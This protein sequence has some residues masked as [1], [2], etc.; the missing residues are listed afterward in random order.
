MSAATQNNKRIALNTLFLY[1]RMLVTMLVSLYTSRVVLDKLGVTDYGI[2]NIVGGIVTMLGF[3]NNSMSNAVQRYMSFEIGKNNK[4]GVNVIFNISLT[5]HFCIAIIVLII[6]EICGV[7]YLNNYMNIPSNRLE[8]ANWVLQCSILTT[9]FTIIQVPYNAIIISYERMSIFAYISILEVTLKLAIVFLLSIGQFDKL[10]LYSILIAIVTISILI[11]YQQYCKKKFI[12][13]RFRF[14]KDWKLL[15]QLI[16]FASWN[17]LG[18]LAWIFTGQ[19]V[20]LILNFFWGPTLNAARGLADQVNGA[21]T[22]FISNFQTAVNPQIIKS[23]ATEHIYEMKSLLYRST[24]FSFY[25]MLALALPL[26]INMDFILHIWLKDVPQYTTEFC[27]LTL[28]CSLIST[29]SNLLAQVARA[30]GDIRNYQIGISIMLFLNFPLSYIFLKEGYSPTC[31]ITINI[32]I[33][34][35]LI[36]I[37]VFFI[38]NMAQITLKEFTLKAL[39][40]ITL[41]T[42]TSIILPLLTFHYLPQN[43]VTFILNIAISIISVCLMSYQLGINTKEREYLQNILKKASARFKRI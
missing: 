35:A 11:I 19:G 16:S 6:M 1:I 26:I 42:S 14:N 22:R 7:W 4:A 43:T 21:V 41:V 24:R 13:T 2:Y 36:F 33:Q 9:L 10:K 18:E 3:L 17:M 32:C 29:I 39:Y 8:A 31:T 12:E 37:R 30:N 5:A 34:F 28:I 23:Y 27:Q 40:P 38:R 15:K 25:L 20:N